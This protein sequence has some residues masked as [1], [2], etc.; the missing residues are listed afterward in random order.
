MFNST[1]NNNDNIYHDY[2]Y[3]INNNKFYFLISFFY[4]VN[5]IMFNT[6]QNNI[7]CGA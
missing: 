1:I 5:S 7:V 4:Y 6:N 2:I 3:K